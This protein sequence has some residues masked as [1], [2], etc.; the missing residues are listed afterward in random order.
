MAETSC[1]SDHKFSGFSVENLVFEPNIGDFG[2]YFFR[3]RVPRL[4]LNVT[5]AK[6]GGWRR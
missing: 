4:Y 5:M 2:A 1:Y 6:Y 3:I